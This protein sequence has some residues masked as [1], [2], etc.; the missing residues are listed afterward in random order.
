[1][2]EWFSKYKN[3]LKSLNIRKRRNILN[4]DEVDFSSECMKSQE[5]LVS[6]EIRK[7]YQISSKNRKWLIIIE[8]INA[9]KDYLF[10]SLII[11]IQGQDIMI[12]WFEDELP[13]NTYVMLSRSGFISDKIVVEFLKHY[14]KNLDADADAE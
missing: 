11:I 12:S 7:H 4:F 8:M 2:I 5:I 3:A 14:I 6:I 13:K 10:S 9:V 1:M